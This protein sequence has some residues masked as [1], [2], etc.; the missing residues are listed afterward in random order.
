MKDRN[1]F[2]DFVNEH[3]VAC[4]GNWGQMLMSAIKNGL[5]DVYAGLEDR[6][7]EF[8][9]L[10]EIIESHLDSGIFDQE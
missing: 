8:V 3:A 9:E 10:V 7:Y 2:A 5:P 6:E 4:G 1:T